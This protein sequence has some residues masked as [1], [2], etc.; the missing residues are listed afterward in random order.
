MDNRLHCLDCGALDAP[1]TC[2]LSTRLDRL[3]TRVDTLAMQL[4]AVMLQA[5]ADT[6][7]YVLIEE[8]T[9]Q[10]TARVVA[11]ARAV[12]DAVEAALGIDDPLAGLFDGVDVTPVSAPVV[13]EL[14][15][16]EF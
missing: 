4:R 11:Q 13:V 7:R 15:E 10:A 2:A 12:L 3:I 1:C 9:Q 16:K 8:G 14:L 6:R 5:Q